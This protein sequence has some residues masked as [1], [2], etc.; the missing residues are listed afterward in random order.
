MGIRCKRQGP[1]SHSTSGRI[2]CWASCLGLL[3]LAL[4]R[5]S[6]RGF[7]Q[8]LLDMR[9]LGWLCRRRC[10]PYPSTSERPSSYL[11]AS[12]RGLGCGVSL[13]PRLRR[14]AAIHIIAAPCPAA[15]RHWHRPLSAIYLDDKEAIKPV[16]SLLKHQLGSWAEAEAKSFEHRLEPRLAL[17]HQPKRSVAIAARI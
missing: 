15:A 1:S 2:S 17:Q 8:S 7:L 9:R 6:P 16:V 10:L 3:L 13:S 12:C 11:R 5:R 4:Q 14:I